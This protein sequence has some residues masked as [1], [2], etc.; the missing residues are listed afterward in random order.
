[1]ER[2]SESKNANK[3]RNTGGKETRSGRHHASR[4]YRRPAI[5]VSLALLIL[6][7]GGTA[8]VF[9]YATS[10]SADERTVGE[11]AMQMVPADPEEAPIPEITPLASASEQV[12]AAMPL[13]EKIGQM[14][15]IGF[16][17]GGLD[18]GVREA[19]QQ[20]YVGGIII[21]DRNIASHEQ[22]AGMNAALQQL[23]VEAGHRAKLMIALDQEGGKTRRFTDIGPFYSQPMIGEMHDAAPG[24]AQLQASAAARDLK[25]LGF[26]TNLAPVAD[27]S[28]GW[29]TVM[30]VR[31]FSY[32]AE[33]T[34][35]LTARAVK[36]YKSASFISCAKHFPGHGSADGDSELNLPTVESDLETIQGT[37]LPPFAAAIEVGV[38]MIMTAHLAVPALDATGTPA[39]LSR[40][41]ITDLLR[42]SMGFEGVVITDDLEMGAIMDSYGI[43]EAAVISVMAGA[44]IVMV[45]HTP[46]LQRD[47]YDALVEA[48]KSGQIKE[49][50]ID[51]SVVRILDMKKK[52]RLGLDPASD[53]QAE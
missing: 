26:N 4:W 17:G 50:D 1:M 14:M 13:E 31:S 45:A 52:Y 18:A 11:T 38:P 37:D 53:S 5:V 3:Q 30:D 41:I 12:V 27:V 24:A 9:F 43:G 49:S 21:F 36:G 34:A 15:M 22:V 33:F 20:R 35:E 23:A 29:G 39:T 25:Q 6:A 19:I 42:G 51:K 40:P 44:D 2:G 48:V 10:S 46:E 47:A 7:I 28:A 32:D 16:E 8:A